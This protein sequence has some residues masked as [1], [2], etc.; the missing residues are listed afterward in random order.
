MFSHYS[1]GYILQSHLRLSMQEYDSVMKI[2]RSLNIMWGTVL[3]SNIWE[4]RSGC[5]LKSALNQIIQ[6]AK[7]V[8]EKTWPWDREEKE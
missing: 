7:V 5:M 6:A 3:T 8:I 2:A 4:T 1:T